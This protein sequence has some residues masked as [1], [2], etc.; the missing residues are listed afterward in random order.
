VGVTP[1]NRKITS[2]GSTGTTRIKKKVSNDIPKSIIGSDA[3]RF[4][5]YSHKVFFICTPRFRLKE[6]DEKDF[7]GLLHSIS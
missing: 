4:K 1:D 2:A 6:T 7:I 3:N 5:Q